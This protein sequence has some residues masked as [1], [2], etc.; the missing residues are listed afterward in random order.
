MRATVY[1]RIS[2]DRT[3]LEA[4]VTRQLEDCRKR[5][6]ERGWAVVSEH[7]D[8]DRSAT[9]GKRREGFE[10]MLE[11]L[12][13][14]EID[15]VI[16]WTLDRL[17]R[18][19]RDE[20]RLYELCRRRDAT[21]SLVRGPDIEFGTPAGRYVADNLGSLARLEV[22]MKS[23]R[24]QRAQ[25]QAAKD[26]RRVGGRRPFGYEQDGVTIREPEA[27][28]VREGYEQL[29]AGVPLAQIARYWNEQGFT[30]GQTRYKKPHKGEPSLWRSDSVRMVLRNPRNAGKRAYKGEIV[31]EAVWPALV[32]EHTWQ[33]AVSMLDGRRGRGTSA[34]ALLTGI[35]LCGVC[36]ATVHAGGAGRPRVRGYR[37]SGT[38]GHFSRMAEPVEDY[39]T[40]V[41]LARLARPDAA[42]LLI[43]DARPD[44]DK[45]R[46]EA[47]AVRA[48]LDGLAIEFADGE[49]TASQLRSATKR[50]RDKLGQVESVM[51]DAGRADLLGP[52][53]GAQDMRSTWTG[54]TTAT[55][56]EVIDLL[57]TVT[58]HPP[59]RGTRTF[60]PESVGIEWKAT[61]P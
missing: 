46:G 45:L 40:E 8:N 5:A 60:R 9:S 12:D 57:A 27:K 52:L 7:D 19:R 23:D 26:G 33:A 31:G 18:N 47:N 51:A 50:L 43:D 25:E 2:Q 22:E 10:A 29:L 35:A 16:A 53:V 24:Q 37:C 14:G 59:G 13:E 34:Q 56:R 54:M 55:Q 48:R 39:V 21:I 20:L 41:I 42:A 3:G 36:G 15:V 32:P 49:L 4:G 58:L 28:A 61:A 17:Q 30:T 11:E 1:L 38:G 6:A 44:L